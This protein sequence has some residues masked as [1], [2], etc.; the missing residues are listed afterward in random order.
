M[1]AYVITDSTTMLRRSLRRMRRYPSLTFFV[2]GMPVV[3]LLLFVYVFGGTLGAGLGGA[4][5]ADCRSAPR[6]TARSGATPTSPTCSP[7]S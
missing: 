7:G 6:V 1:T 5:P 4:C 2:A 3:F